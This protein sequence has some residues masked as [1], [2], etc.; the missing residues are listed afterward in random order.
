[1]AADAALS[2]GQ[3]LLRA[4]LR[5]A[6]G[7]FQLERLVRF[8]A[9]FLPTWQTRHLLYRGRTRLPLAG[10]RVLQAE[11]YVRPP[12]ARPLSVR[13]QPGPAAASPAA[14]TPEPSPRAGR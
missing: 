3:R 6:H 12:R 4:L 14:A 11:A 5:R 9:K 7:R 13:W 8:N 10:L 2:R 1:M